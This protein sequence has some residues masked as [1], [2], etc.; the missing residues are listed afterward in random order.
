MHIRVQGH[1]SS[2]SSSPQ[3]TTQQYV[4][5]ILTTSKQSNQFQVDVLSDVARIQEAYYNVG[6]VFLSVRINH[7]AHFMFEKAVNL[8]VQF[9]D[10]TKTKLHLTREAAFNLFQIYR[11][12]GS[13]ELALQILY[14]HLTYD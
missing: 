9:P 7:L 8:A 4:E 10:L 3:K 14:E 5:S 2:S 6:R 13:N 12:T 1:S 11:F